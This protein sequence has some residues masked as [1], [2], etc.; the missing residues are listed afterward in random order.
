MK[1]L[2][3]IATIF[4]PLTWLTGFF[5]QNFGFEVRHVSGWGTFVALGLGTELVALAGLLALLQAAR[6][7][8]AAYLVTLKAVFG[9]WLVASKNHFPTLSV[10]VRELVPTA[11]APLTVI[12]GAVPCPTMRP[13]FFERSTAVTL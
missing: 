12:V 8:L 3:V 9:P 11:A 7:V 5:G 13:D 2:T 10:T 1:Q 6:L 4:L